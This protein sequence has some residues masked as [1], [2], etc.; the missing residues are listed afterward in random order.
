VRSIGGNK[1]T[2]D[3]YDTA[4]EEKHK[5]ITSS[6]FRNAAGIILVFDL[7]NP[8]SWE[9]IKSTWDEVAFYQ[10]KDIRVNKILIGNKT[11]LGKAVDSE[12]V[13]AWAMDVGVEY[14]ETSA[15]T[16]SGVSDAF[17]KLVSR[18]VDDN[19]YSDM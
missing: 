17:T 19:D 9:Q 1:A 6:L 10:T 15:K 7:K 4:G 8:D 12:V 5:M 14:F 11:D 2:I 16:G 13:K 3:I 18:M